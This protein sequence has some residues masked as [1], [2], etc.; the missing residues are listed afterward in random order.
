MDIF[1]QFQT[2]E[3]A[4]VEGVWIPLDATTKVKIARLQNPRHTACLKR[5][6]TPYIKPGMRQ[7]DIPDDV[8][9]EI[10]REAVAETILVD[11]SGVERDGQPV[12]YSKDA[13]LEACRVKDFYILVVTAAGTMETFRTA[14]L[15]ELEKN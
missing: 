2:D 4:E 8:Y 5:L 12:P 13:A 9:N 7:S 15:A 10:A 11:W 3:K 14:R 6:S 1:K